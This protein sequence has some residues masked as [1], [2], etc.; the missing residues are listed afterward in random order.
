MGMEWYLIVGFN[1]HFPKISDVEHLF[2]CLAILC[3][4]WRNVH[5]NPLPIVLDQVTYIFVV[6]L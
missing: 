2:M 5:S 4:L 1:C 6:E 3:L